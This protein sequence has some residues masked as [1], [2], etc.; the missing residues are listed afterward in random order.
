MINNDCPT[1][2]CKLVGD[3]A[4]SYN[5]ALS[6]Y[7]KKVSDNVL[8]G[9]RA[10]YDRDDRD[11]QPVGFKGLSAQEKFYFG[12]KEYSRITEYDGNFFSI[13]D[14]NIGSKHPSFETSYSGFVGFEPYSESKKE[15]N[16]MW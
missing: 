16:F 1:Y 7:Y 4:M 15:A 8:T 9:F 10:I 6:P 13:E 5:P 12:M 3:K 11:L 2:R 14:V